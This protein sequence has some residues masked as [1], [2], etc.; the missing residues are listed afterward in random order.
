M[1]K[2]GKKYIKSKELKSAEVREYAV[3]QAVGLVKK[4]AYAK[5]D[6]SVDV[7]IRLGVNPKYSD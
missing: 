4:A 5:F 1:S 3:D 7:S 2:R 6:E